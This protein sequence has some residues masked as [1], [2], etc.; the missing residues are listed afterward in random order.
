MKIY[1]IILVLSCC[2]SCSFYYSKNFINISENA[3]A[4]SER[5]EKKDSGFSL[6]SPNFVVSEPLD[7]DHLIR[8][9]KFDY[10]CVK[11]RNVEI[12]HYQDYY[13]F[14]GFPEIRVRADCIK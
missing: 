13:F 14:F 10:A 9:I 11:L 7:A 8:A 5:V 2:I 6:L 1:F 3:E 12:D 4:M